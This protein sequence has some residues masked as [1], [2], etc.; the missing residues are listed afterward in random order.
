MELLK[1]ISLS[2][3]LVLCVGFIGT[4]QA[5]AELLD[6]NNLSEGEILVYLDGVAITKND[7]SDR[8]EILLDTTTSS[9]ER[10]FRDISDV[11][12]IETDKNKAIAGRYCDGTV[13]KILSAPSFTQTTY[14][15]YLT[16]GTARELAGKLEVGTIEAIATFIGG[17][18]PH[19]FFPV[20]L[21]FANQLNRATTASNIRKFTD[22]NNSVRLRIVNSNVSSTYLYKVDYWDGI[23]L[24][25]SVSAGER[26]VET[27][28]SKPVGW[29]NIN[30]KWYYNDSYGN[31]VKG[32][33]EVG[34]KWYYLDPTS[35]AM[36]IGWKQIS[37]KW[38]YLDTINGDMKKGWLKLPDG[39]WYYLDPS[40][41]AMQT[42]WKEIGGK[43]YYMYSTGKMATNTVIDGW[44]IDANGV[45]TKIKSV[46]VIEEE[47]KLEIQ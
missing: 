37:G 14:D 35:G 9:I 28:L 42:G 19:A 17:W 16:V 11:T 22:N 39:Y 43:W 2:L 6:Y 18:L 13:K 45:A 21:I 24:D 30:G 5:N 40:S 26:V 12:T 47:N 10:V 7:I 4:I 29:E 34:A 1:K 36:Q 32:W 33:K 15:M 41:G 3:V 46:Q 25:Y 38:Y 44:R 23:N 31:R 8:G 27:I 20:T